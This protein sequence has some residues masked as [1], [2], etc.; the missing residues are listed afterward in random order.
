M[1]TFSFCLFLILASGISHVTHAQQ[2][3]ST[4]K[5]QAIEDTRRLAAR[6]SL[7]DARSMQ[8]RRLVL[9]RLTQEN[10]ITTQYANDPAM[11]Q[12]KLHDLE[13][14]Y[15][16]KLKNILTALQYQRYVAQLSPTG[17]AQLSS[18]TQSSNR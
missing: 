15:G 1:K 9:E 11:M 12:N 2:S 8:V 5:A 10:E 16:E 7:D 18:G 3:P 17:P 6:I 4:L 14:Q 13:R